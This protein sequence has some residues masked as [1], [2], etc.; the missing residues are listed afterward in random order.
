MSSRSPRVLLAIAASMAVLVGACSTAAT[1]APS[2]APTIGPVPTV[3]APSVAA[4]SV[5]GS[6]AASGG[7]GTAGCPTK[8]PAALPASDTR[9]VTITTP[10]GSI[11]IKVEGKLAPIA[12][13]NFVALASC[14]YYD[15]VVFHRLVPGFVIQGGDGQYGRAPDVDA[16]HVGQGGPGYTIQDEPVVGNY[17]RGAVAMARTS[18]PNSQ[19]SQFFICLA[20]LTQQL[21]TSGDYVIIGHVTTGMDTVDAIAA[22]PNSGDPNNEA[23]NPEPM[24]KVT[25][26][27]P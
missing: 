17:V 24:T 26:A 3:A 11:A 2:P 18:D 21:P 23:T 6:A 16:A 15:N 4:P 27:T 13:G 19:G 10:K 20:D 8:Q 12:T 7:A 25:V 14:G 9:T 1:P 22:E 5:G